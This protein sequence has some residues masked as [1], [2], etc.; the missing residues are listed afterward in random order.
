MGEWEMVGSV[1]GVGRE[2]KVGYF[3]VVPSVS[4][5]N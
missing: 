1:V 5:I 4:D 3:S 2:L